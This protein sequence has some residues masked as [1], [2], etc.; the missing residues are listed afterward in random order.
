MN[1]KDAY[2]L[3]ETLMNGIDPIT[4]ELLPEDHVCQEPD[5]LRALHRALM[6]LRSCGDAPAEPSRV[7]QSGKLNAGRPWTQE[8]QDRLK[9]LHEAGTSMEEMCRLL[10]RRKRGVTN[11]LIYLGLADSDRPRTAVNP[12]H[13]RAGTPWSAEDDQTLWRMW[14]Q[15]KTEAQIAREL[16][17]SEY[18]IHCRVERF[19]MTDSEDGEVEPPLLPPWSM[20]DVQMLQRLH[21]IGCTPEEIA[22]QMNRPVKSI[23]ARMFYMGLTKESPISL[24]GEEKP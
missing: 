20:E 2:T 5:V 21:T 9:Q 10:Q 11:Q 14:K 3:L 15:G 22:R 6:A 13:P 4:G 19:G 23:R 24:R 18:A 17:R 8:D 12:K 16:Q 1:A 7:S